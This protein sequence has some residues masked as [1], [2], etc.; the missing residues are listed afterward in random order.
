MSGDAPH[1]C[2]RGFRVCLGSLDGRGSLP[3][4]LACIKPC[5]TFWVLQPCWTRRLTPCAV[6]RRAKALVAQEQRAQKAAA[7]A[8]AEE[9]RVQVPISQ[10]SSI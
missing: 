10:K 6:Q 8:A 5:E 3:A 9:A 2:I 7:S 4:A 1:E